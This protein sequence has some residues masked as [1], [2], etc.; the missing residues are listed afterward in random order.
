MQLEPIENGAKHPRLHLSSLNRLTVASLAT[1]LS[2]MTTRRLRSNE[3][4]MID[5]MQ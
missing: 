1:R 4:Q 2:P 3:E 5:S